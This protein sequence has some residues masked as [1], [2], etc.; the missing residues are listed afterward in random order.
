MD[1][2]YIDQLI[3]NYFEGTTSLEEEHILREFFAQDDVPAHLRTW[4]PLFRSEAT[5]AAA[6]LD[7]RFDRRLQELI[8]E[9]H[10]AARSITMQERLRPLFKA[11]AFVAFAIVIGTAVE[12][13]TTADTAAEATEQMIV[14]DELDPG[15]TTPLNIRSAEV[16]ETADTLTN[17]Q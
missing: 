16:L 9:K 11:A 1:Y 5:L 6:K 12:H 4:Q 7:E 8:G 17:L 3:D 10:V 14:Q 2:K 15:G 13:A